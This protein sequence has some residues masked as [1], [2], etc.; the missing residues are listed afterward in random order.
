MTTNAESDPMIETAAPVVD[1]PAHVPP[2]VRRTKRMRRRN[3]PAFSA[4]NALYSLAMLCVFRLSH[5]SVTNSS[6]W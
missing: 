5:T 3:R 4:S 6:S 2:N 1:S